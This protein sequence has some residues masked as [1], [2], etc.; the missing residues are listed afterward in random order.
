[1]KAQHVSSWELTQLS[2]SLTLLWSMRN[3][4]VHIPCSRNV[5]HVVWI[6]IPQS[7]H[8]SPWPNYTHIMTRIHFNYNMLLYHCNCNEL[9]NAEYIEQ[10]LGAQK[11]RDMFSIVRAINLLYSLINYALGDIACNITLVHTTSSPTIPQ[12]CYF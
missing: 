5:P 1:M 4:W 11:R 9:F 3:M 6:Q 8:T 7:L 12:L 2:P 10:V